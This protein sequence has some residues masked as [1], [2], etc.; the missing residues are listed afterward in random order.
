M[1]KLQVLR[2]RC[3]NGPGKETSSGLISHGVFSTCWRKKTVSLDTA[4][5]WLKMKLGE[6]RKELQREGSAINQPVDCA[7]RTSWNQME[8]FPFVKE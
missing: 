4:S 8:V 3:K 1:L 2:R 6:N 7:H 5:V